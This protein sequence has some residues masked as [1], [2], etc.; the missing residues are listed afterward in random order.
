MSCRQAHLV[1]ISLVDENNSYSYLV[2]H[3]RLHSRLVVA[4]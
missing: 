1:I 4:D 3:T 2:G